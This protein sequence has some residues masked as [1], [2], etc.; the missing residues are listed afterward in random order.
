[1][2]SGGAGQ[3]MRTTFLL[4]KVTKHSTES[5]ALEIAA[6][7]PTTGSGTVLAFTT[8]V[9]SVSSSVPQPPEYQVC[10]SAAPCGSRLKTSRR[11]SAHD[12]MLTPRGSALLIGL[13][14]RLMRYSQLEPHVSPCRHW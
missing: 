7:A 11:P 10:S 14:A 6:G 1:M 12:A 8:L 5:G 2:P 13:A 9:G 3:A 4:A